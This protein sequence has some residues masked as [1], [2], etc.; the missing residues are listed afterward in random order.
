[1]NLGEGCWGMRRGG[2]GDRKRRGRR[3]KGQTQEEGKE[4]EEEAAMRKMEVKTMKGN[5]RRRN[6]KALNLLSTGSHDLSLRH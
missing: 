2:A 6:I 1:M 5:R 4:G 3:R